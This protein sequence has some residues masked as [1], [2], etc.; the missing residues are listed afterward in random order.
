MTD[1]QRNQIREYRANGMGYSKIAQ[2]LG[3]SENTVQSF[4]GRKGLGGVVAF[5]PNV[6]LTNMNV[7]ECGGAE[8]IQNP[9]RKLK[10]F[11]SD[12]CRNKWW[13][14]HLDQVDRRANYKY[15][16]PHC[17]KPF[18]AYGNSKRKYCSY[19]GYIADR[20]VVSSNERKR[21]ACSSMR[22]VYTHHQRGCGIFQYWH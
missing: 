22:E 1:E 13:N 6:T 11:C 14:E 17:H 21:S 9:G 18:A 16:C 8:V 2:A 19:S 4:C 3:L 15:V 7:F 12:I 20:F 5:T 10:R